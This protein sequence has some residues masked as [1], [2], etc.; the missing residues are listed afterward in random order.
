MTLEDRTTLTIPK[1]VQI[2]PG[3]LREGAEVKAM[4]EEQA[5]LKLVTSIE[6]DK[7]SRP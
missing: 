2:A 7:L 3:T 1:S 5:E 4:Y 6:V